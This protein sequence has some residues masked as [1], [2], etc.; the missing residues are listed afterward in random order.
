M[1]F[2][3]LRRFVLIYAGLA[4]VTAL[5]S[6]GFGLL[7]GGGVSRAV[8]VGLY[9]V[10]AALLTG[11]FV[12]G[13]SGPVRPEWREGAR[14]GAGFIPRGVRKATPDERSG[15]VRSSLLLFALGFGLIILAAAADPLHT[16][17]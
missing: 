11:S 6:I 15:A 16:T 12:L 3:A 17:F 13:S 5:V 1:L 10:G 14:G 8:S 7:A 2:T 9:V 4:A